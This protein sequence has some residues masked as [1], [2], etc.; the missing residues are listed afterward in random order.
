MT[1]ED[2]RALARRR[3]LPWASV[4]ALLLFALFVGAPLFLGPGDDDAGAGD[5]E[6]GAISV[7][8]D[9]PAA[10]PGA[11]G[12]AARPALAGDA[13][14]PVG[15]AGRENAGAVSAATVDAAIPSLGEAAVRRD[16]D[17]TNATRGFILDAVSGDP[18][19]GAN[20]R[21]SWF[22]GSTALSRAG[23][24]PLAAVIRQTAGDGSFRFPEV[25]PEDPRLRAHVQINHPGYSPEVCVLH[26]RQDSRGRW[27]KAEGAGDTPD[28]VVLGGRGGGPGT[29]NRI[30]FYIRRT[31]TVPLTILAPNGGG[32]PHAP[33]AVRPWVDDHSFL[34]EPELEI[35]WS[36]RLV[37]PGPWRVL[38]TDERGSLR[39][40]FSETPWEIELLHPLF[41]LHGARQPGYPETIG[42]QRILF[43]DAQGLILEA[44][45]GYLAGHRLIDLDGRPLGECELEVELE[46]MPALRT[47]TDANGW[48]ELGIHPFPHPLPLLSLTNRRAGRLTVLSP[49]YWNR[50]M[51][52]ALP[53]QEPE[54]VL[55]ARPAEFLRFR[56]VSGDAE[57]RTPVAPDSLRST[58]DM[59]LMRL[60]ANGEVSYCGVLPPAGSLVGILQSGYLP[61]SVLLPDRSPLARG[62]ALDLGELALARGW[63]RE[64][65]LRGAGAE[66]LSSARLSVSRIA[67]VP[68]GLDGLEVHR[69][70][71]GADGRVSIG[72]LQHGEYLLSV[73]GPLLQSF[74]ADATIFEENLDEPLGLPLQLSDEEVVSVSGLIG[75]L[76]PFETRGVTVVER[77]FIS[78]RE[79][80]LAMPPY[81]LSSAGVFGSIRK[82]R[83][84]EAVEVTICTTTERGEQAFRSRG[85]GPPDFDF[86][87][88]RLR[89]PPHAVLEFFTPGYPVVPPPLNLG[90]EGEAGSEVSARMRL[91]GDLLMID[92]LRMGRYVLRW[93]GIDGEE[94]S[95]LFEVRNK[96]GGE[97]RGR[98]ERRLLPREALEIDIVDSRGARIETARVIQE[99]TL[100]PPGLRPGHPALENRFFVT[101]KTR[102]ETSFSVEGDGYLPAFVTVPPGEVVPRRIVLYRSD[103]RVMGRV[104]DTGGEPFTGILEIDWTP[105][106]PALIR[107]GQPIVVEVLNGRLQAEGLLPQPRD[108]IFRPKGSSSFL[109]RRLA[110]PEERRLVDLG[111]VRL[112]ETRTLK[113]FAYLPD[114]RPAP[115][116]VVALMPIDRAYRYPGVDPIDLARLEW[117]TKTDE[118]GA[119]ELGELPLVLP[120]R[121]ALVARL[122][123]FSDSI[124]ED[125]VFEQVSRELVLAP[126]TVIE[127]NIGYVNKPGG[128]H[129]AFALE[130]QADPADPGSR[131][132]LGEL[133]PEF[134]GLHRF[135]G[136]RP[137]QYR[138]K[139]GL[140][141]A[142]EPV[143]PA[144]EDV[145]LPVGGLARLNFV[146]EGLVVRGRAVLNGLPVEKGWVILTH[147][148]GENGGA[149]VGR[150][151]DGEF[152]MVDPPNVLRAWAAVIPEE[153]DQAR[154]NIYRG[155]A[156]PVEVKN[157]RASVRAGFLEV[158]SAGYDIR[159]EL[160]K[161]L[162]L[163]NPGST[164]S[165]DHWE[166]DG[167]RFRDVEDAELIESS[168]ITFG[169]LLPGSYRF[170]IRSETG[171]VLRQFTV[172][173]KGADVILPIR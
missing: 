47:R 125:P 116:A 160:G 72:G 44:E 64:V 75:G 130:F 170:T 89:R 77:Y 94:E 39:L 97:I 96:F 78:G 110:L 21:L 161:D 151:L 88:L 60:G 31:L 150:V 62:A 112:G 87:E 148:P 133:P 38:F 56:L 35:T 24:S 33:L 153:K 123:G 18:V 122:A 1:G 156:L 80:P 172:P 132:D 19:A 67:E 51:D 121:W 58:L 32:L 30:E 65:H 138:V 41:F 140:R 95:F 5:S 99:E 135:E 46:G 8:A 23:L 164:L 109:R 126:E 159:L 90:L 158:S 84:V 142:Y 114:G 128:D 92:N 143:P 12:Q 10:G 13:V 117:K 7:P 52:I 169:L 141:D 108:F 124:E 14:T 26:G 70:E 100:L 17:E 45:Q 61:F 69:Y 134:Y 83:G 104:F 173:L 34:D 53:L 22:H 103:T 91:S 102:E 113:G 16:G 37:R 168:R 6:H 149:R 76:G 66:A 63:T 85:E 59:S 29:G 57:T 27:T 82:L 136:V 129:H 98:V 131:V 157:Y 106:T 71:P 147:N 68:A 127:L 118:Q 2:N 139:W 167:R 111:V 105:R 155:E 166:W 86:G 154:Q 50:S 93:K 25:D 28:L 119:F 40:P 55:E 11:S 120:P 144:W 15:G 42:R 152:E 101:V 107:Y 20:V 54:L 43:Q 79:E 137:G 73:D 36:G 3:W 162:L 115:G 9:G 81:P 48:F 165:F 171:S 4:L 49:R 145:F 163:R 74:S 146:V